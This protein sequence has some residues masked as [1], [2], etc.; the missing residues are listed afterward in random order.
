ML[1]PQDWKAEWIGRDETG[2]KAQRRGDRRLPARMLRTEFD[3]SERISRAML[4]VS[5]LGL[6]EVYL[7]G[8][9][10]G[11]AVADQVEV[12]SQLLVDD[13]VGD[14]SPVSIVG[15]QEVADAGAVWV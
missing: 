11:D 8:R 13:D 14:R 3:L 10:V 1:S 12:Q 15:S 6:S 7:N 2:E 9:R 5:G 4:Y